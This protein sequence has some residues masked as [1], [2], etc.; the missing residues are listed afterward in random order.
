MQIE[1]KSRLRGKPK[2]TWIKAVT[3]NKKNM[4]IAFVVAIAVVIQNLYS[5]NSL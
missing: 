2:Q 3:I 1:E 4:K 5:N